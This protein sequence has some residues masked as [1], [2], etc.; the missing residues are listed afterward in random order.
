MDRIQQNI[1]IDD[2]NGCWTRWT[3]LYRDGCRVRSQCRRLENLVLF[4]GV[5]FGRGLYV[6]Y[7]EILSSAWST[8]FSPSSS[9][10]SGLS[11]YISIS[12]ELEMGGTGVV[13]IRRHGIVSE[14]KRS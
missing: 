1:G 3:R 8:C 5:S 10:I 6:E 12:I 2:E 14:S 7:L 9:V 4:T 13:E 11:C